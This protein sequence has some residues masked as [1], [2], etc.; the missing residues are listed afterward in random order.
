[1]AM[2][3]RLS[4]KLISLAPYVG[5]E[6]GFKELIGAYGTYLENVSYAPPELDSFWARISGHGR[7]FLQLGMLARLLVG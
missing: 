3:R 2:A 1:M 5:I 6:D 4:A 7:P